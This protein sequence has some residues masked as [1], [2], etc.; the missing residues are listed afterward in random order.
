MNERDERKQTFRSSI[1]SLENDIKTGAFTMF[2][3][4][5]RGNLLIVCAV[6][7]VQEA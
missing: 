5:H 1:V 4:K 7:G 3:E 6:S 2:R